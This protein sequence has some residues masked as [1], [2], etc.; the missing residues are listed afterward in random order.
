MPISLDR[1]SLKY[2]RLDGYKFKGFN[3]DEIES[4]G[5]LKLPSYNAGDK[6]KK[7]LFVLDYVP[8]EDLKSGTLLGGHQGQLLSNIIR[9]VSEGVYLKESL[10]FSWLA[11]TFNAFR[12]AGKP[13][14]FQNN[15]QVAFAKRVEFI[16][17]RY[18]P[19]VVV[20]MG[21]KPCE[22]FLKEQIDL[23]DGKISP[24][25]GV[26][27]RK[28]I[29]DHEC[30]FYAT[31]S[32]D[33]LAV[34]AGTGGE[35]ALCGYVGRNLSHAISDTH[36]FRIDA[37]RVRNHKSVL[38][39]TV[40]KF[41][42]LMD[43]V[44]ATE[45]PVAI[46]TETKNL[47]RLANGLL[48]VQISKCI[49]FG[50]LIPIHHK[51]TP[52]LPEELRYIKKRLK[53]FFESKNRNKYHIYTNAG[54]DLNVL[55]T[56]LGVRFFKNDVYD[57]LAGEF[58]LDENLKFLMT[59]TGDYYYSLG[60]LSVQYGYDG[61]LTAEFGKKDRATIE[62][63]DLDAALIRYCTLDTVVPFAIAEQQLAL[64]KQIGHAKF[65]SMVSQQISDMLHTF[66]RMEINGNLIDVDYLFYLKT[67]GSPI[68]KELHRLE[69]ELLATKAVVKANKI[70][71]KKGGISSTGW[72][73]ETV[74]NKFSLT[75]PEHRQLLFFDVLGLE[76]IMKGKS[77]AGKIDKKFQE[78]YKDVEEVAMF[79]NLGKAR[80]LRD[81]YVNS[82]IKLLASSDDF[83]LDKR[84]RPRYNYLG[85]VT[86]RTSAQDP[87]LQQVPARSALG[88]QI[89]RLFIA[90]PGYLYIKVD[91]RVHEVRC[92]GLISF[93]KNLAEVFQKAKDLRDE[94][95]R[96]PN[97][98]LAKRLKLEADVHVLNAS[99]FFSVAVEKVDKEVRNAVKS[100]VFGLIYQ[101]AVKTL[102]TNLGKSLKFT[103][104]L[105]SN[106][107]KRF[108]R[109]MKWIEDIKVYA[110]KHLYAESPLGLRRHLWGY[111]LPKD[112]PNRGRVHGDMDRRAVNS[113]VQGMGA[114]FM[115]IGARALDKLWWN[116]LRKEKRDT[117]L[118]ICNSV[119]DSL[120]NKS[121][122]ATFLENLGLIEEALTTKVREE[123]KA[124]HGFD[125]GVDLEIDFEIGS[126]LSNCESWDFS[127]TQL[128]DIVYESMLFQKEQLKHDI[129]V[130]SSM[131]E[132]FVTGW[133]NAPKWLKNQAKNIGWEYDF[134]R[135]KQRR[136]D[137]IEQEKAVKAIEESKKLLAA[138]GEK[139]PGERKLLK[140]SDS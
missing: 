91:Y 79:T 32:L 8:Q 36:Q 20:L 22:Q 112:N 107:Q 49:D 86:G 65:E 89:K 116:T 31:L 9:K 117:G 82:F 97:P 11:C 14:S 126:A 124:R 72:M 33:T 69:R 21:R 13:K 61:Y 132:V 128:E 16:I 77:G 60:N 19:D 134:A 111:L 139:K 44:E 133:D 123:V 37:E 131:S 99:Y 95:R 42:K 106:F 62:A 34:G 70:L 51:D 1:G 136:V 6:A 103:E 25:L 41:D 114:Q 135:I 73:G 78:H 58:T 104:N 17:G 10:R 39:S 137:R 38:I 118:R 4:Y 18:K 130:K 121:P 109:G 120:E 23:T 140:G 64:A 56:Q 84:I 40:K 68:E 85:V 2:T 43:V 55:R 115:A 28:T 122:Y 96:R 63:H 5:H 129:S 110:Q 48:T 26:P 30:N 35:S 29:R 66:S 98:T 15:A 125:F 74:V 24:W 27:L 52:F 94:Y 92:W 83:K 100:V 88:K 50:Y 113:P 75:K 3:E 102:A 76:P 108:P 54:F 47:N 53:K 87:N 101:M 12:T 81:S 71:M 46:D 127:L 93:D 138:K 7:I 90:E 80:K 67:P 119:H 59:V 105:V 57:I 45:G